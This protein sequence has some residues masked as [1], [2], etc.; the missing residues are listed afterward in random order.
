MLIAY[1]SGLVIDELDSG[2]EVLM[3]GE[4]FYAADADAPST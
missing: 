1:Q 2:M 4:V 3:K